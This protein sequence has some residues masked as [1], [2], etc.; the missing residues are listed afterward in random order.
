MVK[1]K[2]GRWKEV[3]DLFAR[4]YDIQSTNL[5]PDHPDLAATMSHSAGLLKAMSKLGDAEIV[6]RTVS[7]CWS[8]NNYYHAALMHSKPDSKPAVQ[9]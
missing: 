7:F 6:Y 9:A 4:A 3:Q 5:D 8:T 1:Y 2:L